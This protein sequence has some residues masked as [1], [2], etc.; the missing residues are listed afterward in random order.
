LPGLLLPTPGGGMTPG[1]KVEPCEDCG[2]MKP[3]GAKHHA[4]LMRMSDVG[5][6]SHPRCQHGTPHYRTCRRV[7]PPPCCW[8]DYKAS[9][10]GAM[11]RPEAKARLQK[12]METQR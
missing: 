8:G 6:A 1:R 2:S 9:P 7:I 12:F 10:S 4:P 3:L 5:D 11:P